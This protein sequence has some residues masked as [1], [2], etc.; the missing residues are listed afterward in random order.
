MRN[1]LNV[2]K[3][4][5]MNRTTSPQKSAPMP[6][7]TTWNYF[8]IVV[9]LLPNLVWILRDRRVWPWDQAWYG[10]VSVDLWFWLGHSLKGWWSEM[11]NG[12]YLKPPGIV[13]LG[14]FFVPF[15][16]IFGSVEAALLFSILLTQFVVLALLF[17]IGQRIAPQS[18]LV[19][20][21]GVV[22][23]AGSQLFVGLSHQFFVEPLQ[24]LAVAWCFYIAS[25]ADDWPKSRT[26]VHLAS[27][28][29]LGVLAKTTTPFYCVVPTLYCAYL[30]VRGRSEWD[31]KAE[32]KLRS[33]RAL[34]VV[35][36]IL[37]IVCCVW[38][39]RN[40]AGVWQHVHDATSGDV[41]LNYG[42]RDSI[43]GKLIVWSRLIN[44]SFL[45]PYLSWGFLAA[46]LMGGGHTIYRLIRPSPQNRSDFGPLAVLSV[47][48][49]GLLLFVFSMNIIVDSR[50][51]YALLPCVVIL[52]MQICVYVPRTAVVALIVLSSAQWV[53]VNRHSFTDTNRFADQSNWLVPLHQNGSQYE[54]LSRVVH[55]T[56]DLGDR[57]NIVGVQEPWLN[58]NSAA[59]FAAKERLKT[60]IRSYFTS[61]GYGEKDLTAAMR[62]I[63]ELRTRYLI[64]L[65][66]QYQS[67]PPDFVNVVSLPVLEQVRRDPRFTACQFPS[68]EGIVVFQFAPR[69]DVSET[70]SPTPTESAWPTPSTATEPPAISAANVE[71][72]DEPAQHKAFTDGCGK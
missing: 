55:F 70:S 10:E 40:L 68:K 57:Y 54:E 21:V 16:G 56:S 35:F 51:M 13:W 39:L 27:A 20:L 37:G 64:T 29:V 36:G 19:P 6:F 9:L 67:T 30:L 45:S 11:I 28:L 15:R 32:W 69:S 58:D 22:F 4:N 72:Q 44:P 41:A 71:S 65:S 60:G 25:R 38:Y 8:L 53:V 5:E 63:E 47:T 3:K 34:V 24:A 61:L 26:A 7:W 2:K 49:V 18:R 43:F 52:F 33:S 66:E 48:Q 62:R 46:I 42:T 23:A 50:Y 31:L 1:N 12:L 59:F 14:Q 17:K